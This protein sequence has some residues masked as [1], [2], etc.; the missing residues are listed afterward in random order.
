ML[1]EEKKSLGGRFDVEDLGEVNCVL[2]ML[3]K[4]DQ[5]LK[6]PVCTVM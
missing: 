2:G 5:K 3:V 6:T 1:N 4:R